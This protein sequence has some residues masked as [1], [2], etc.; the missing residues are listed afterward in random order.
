MKESSLWG[1][2]KGEKEKEQRSGGGFGFGAG[3]GVAWAGRD[4]VSC[5][6]CR[7]PFLT[8]VFVFIHL[9]SLVLFAHNTHYFSN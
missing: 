8:F 2:M 9:L 3:A 1:M 5:V 7:L 6:D 4:A